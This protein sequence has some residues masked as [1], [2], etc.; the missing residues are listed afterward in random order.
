[1]LPKTMRRS[2]LVPAFFVLIL[3]SQDA[4]AQNPFS[5]LHA[6]QGAQ[7]GVSQM[8]RSASQNAGPSQ[9]MIDR[10]T[11]QSM[12]YDNQI[13]HTTTFSKSES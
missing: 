12:S 2:I 10:Q 1:M 8:I 11:A 9:A 5:P 3:L 13:K 4:I 6:L 7:Q